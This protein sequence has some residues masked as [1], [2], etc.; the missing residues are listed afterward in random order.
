MNPQ[1]PLYFGLKQF[2][3]QWYHLQRRKRPGWELT[4]PRAWVGRVG[5]NQQFCFDF[6]VAEIQEEIHAEWA[7]GS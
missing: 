2:G 5:K 6:Y 4:G 7:V 1:E 3:E